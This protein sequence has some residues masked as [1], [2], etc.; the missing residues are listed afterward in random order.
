MKSQKTILANIQNDKEIQKGISKLRNFSNEDFLEHAK[1][2]IK[3]IKQNRMFCVIDSVSNSGMSRN[4]HFHSANKEKNRFYFRQ[5]WALFTALG[6][7]KGNTNNNFRIS[8]CGMDMIFATNYNN[9]HK[10]KNLGILTD[11]ECRK[12]CQM[13]PTTF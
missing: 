12:L 7:S 3:A 11:S 4:I 10:F 5:Y 6:Y 8:G 1:D 9:I 2:Y 13:T